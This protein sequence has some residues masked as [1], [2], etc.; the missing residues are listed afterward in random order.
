MP[1]VTGRAFREIVIIYRPPFS[2]NMVVDIER[3]GGKVVRVGKIVSFILALVPSERLGEVSKLPWVVSWSENV[4]YEA[5]K[6][7]FFRGK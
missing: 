2:S 3:L 5:M 7:D 6:V 1:L 4:P